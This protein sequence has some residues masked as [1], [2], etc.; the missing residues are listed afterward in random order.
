MIGDTSGA[1]SRNLLSAGGKRTRTQPTPVV[2]VWSLRVLRPGKLS[3]QQPTLDG[4]AHERKDSVMV[5]VHA[6]PHSRIGGLLAAFTVLLAVLF[7]IPSPAPSGGCGG[8]GASV[9][10]CDVI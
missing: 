7:A 9:D 2:S 6:S 1:V 8:A 4:D 5:A 3:A 10:W